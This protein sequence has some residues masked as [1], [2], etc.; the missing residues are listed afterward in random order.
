MIVTIGAVKLRDLTMTNPVIIGGCLQARVLSNDGYIGNIL[1][2]RDETN[3]LRQCIPACGGI[4]DWWVGN[5]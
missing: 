3:S 1:F 2:N 4:K 5:V